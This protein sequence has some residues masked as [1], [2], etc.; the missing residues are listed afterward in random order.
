MPKVHYGAQTFELSPR[1]DVEREVGQ[2]ELVRSTS[3]T[4]VAILR[5]PLANG[6]MLAA[7]ISDNIPIAFET[8]PPA[9]V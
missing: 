1:F 5:L 7:V 8:D 6:G 3:S 2:I 9:S 4:T